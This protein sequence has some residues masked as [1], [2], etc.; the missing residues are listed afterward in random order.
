[1]TMIQI[2]E[3]DIIVTTAAV[4]AY[5]LGKASN[6]DVVIPSGSKGIVHMIHSPKGYPEAYTVEF[7]LADLDEFAL[8][9]VMAA[10][11]KPA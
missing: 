10:Q 5:L 2:K 3:L 8:A 1:M 4:D 7:H 9:T 11:L 6:R